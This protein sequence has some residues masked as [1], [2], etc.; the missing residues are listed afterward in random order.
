MKSFLR[1]S[2]Q[3][4]NYRDPRSLKFPLGTADLKMVPLM[5]VFWLWLPMFF[6]LHLLLGNL[7]PMLPLTYAELW[8]FDGCYLYWTNHIQLL[9]LL[10]WKSHGLLHTTLYLGSQTGW[11]SSHFLTVKFCKKMLHWGK[12]MYYLFI[13]KLLIFEMY[14]FDEFWHIFSRVKSSPL[15]R[16]WTFLLPP[17]VFFC[18]FAIHTF[19]PQ[20]DIGFTVLAFYRS[21]SLCQPTCTWNFWKFWK[22]ELALS[23]NGHFHTTKF[24]CL[25]TVCH[26]A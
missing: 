3:Q 7:T 6:S 23:D 14:V 17:K 2:L 22:T 5:E 19:L 12:F 24:S 8:G 20:P 16:Y 18:P 4:S 21:L 26:N 10:S 13:N 1:L 11:L 25:L 9:I 15:S